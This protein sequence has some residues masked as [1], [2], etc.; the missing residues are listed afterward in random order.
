MGWWET[1]HAVATPAGALEAI[2]V[3]RDKFSSGRPL[4]FDL[5]RVIAMARGEMN[6]A[7]GP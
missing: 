5:A 2:Q 7:T 1:G 4:G 3:A 6:A